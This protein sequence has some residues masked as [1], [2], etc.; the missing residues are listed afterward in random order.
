MAQYVVGGWLN[1]PS[2][3]AKR[4]N[5]FRFFF[6]KKK[7]AIQRI[8]ALKAEEEFYHRVISKDPLIGHR[9]QVIEVVLNE[10]LVVVPDK[11]GT[12][13]KRMEVKEQ[14]LANIRSEILSQGPDGPITSG[15]PIAVDKNE[16]LSGSFMTI[17]AESK[18]KVIEQL[19]ND[20]FYTAGVWDLDNARI[21]AVSKPPTHTPRP[22]TI[23]VYCRLPV[24]QTTCYLVSPAG[25]INK[26][27]E[28][29]IILTFDLC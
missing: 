4:N 9:S 25:S 23:T 14:H 10:Y 7:D 15:G 18:E 3:S 17:A 27:L 24:R 5:A 29:K 11:P 1:A 2:T 16:N 6:W 13:D 20:I 28:N 8:E 26:P 19:K 21:F 22:L 12:Y